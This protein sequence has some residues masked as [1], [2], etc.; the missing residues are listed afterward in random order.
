[1]CNQGGPGKPARF[2]PLVVLSN[3]SHFWKR[4][5][6]LL[7]IPLEEVSCIPANILCESYMEIFG[8]ESCGTH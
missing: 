7:L 6:M 3:V 5:I 8:K 4:N 1:M 2:F